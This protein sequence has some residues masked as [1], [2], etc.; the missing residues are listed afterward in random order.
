M[1]VTINSSGAVT[2]SP[3]LAG[4]SLGGE[5]NPV[6]LSR[7]NPLTIIDISITTTGSA[8][9]LVASN[10]SRQHLYIENVSDTDIWYSFTDTTPAANA[11]GSRKLAAGDVYE[12]PPHAVP[13]N[14]VYVYCA[15]SGKDLTAEYA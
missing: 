7:G 6:R 12:A 1:S 14:A 5:E 3:T 8:Q 11:A 10:A 9:L 4:K 2:G 13:T 15:A